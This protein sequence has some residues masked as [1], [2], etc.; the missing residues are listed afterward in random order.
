[1]YFGNIITNGEISI[2]GFR[3]YSKDDVIDNDLPTL[4][5]GWELAKDIYANSV[6]ILH[7]KINTNTFWTFTPKERKVD[8]E[9]DIENFKEHCYNTFGDNIPYVYL[10]ILYGKKSVNKR[11]IKKILSLENPYVYISDNDII[12]IFGDN[13][14]FGVDLNVI[15]YFEGK[16]NKILDK[17]KSIKNSVLIDSKIF[18]NYRD[19][20][21]K[22][23]NKNRLIPYIVRYGGV[24]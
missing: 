9:C 10:D 11:I 7:K 22:I 18:N 2:D 13:I 16:R 19:L 15:S 5:I 3:V 23:K 4:I 12:Y 20:L 21:Y 24:K 14:I 1:M 17:I 6:S 8:F